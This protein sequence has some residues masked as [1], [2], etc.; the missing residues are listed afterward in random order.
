MD[1]HLVDRSVEHAV[2][3]TVAAMEKNLAVY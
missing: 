2:L 3:K 1:G